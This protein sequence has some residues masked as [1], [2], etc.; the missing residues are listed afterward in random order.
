MPHRIFITVAEISGDRHAAQLVRS[1]RAMDP[2]LEIEGYG[3][4][5]LAA[6][7]VTLHRDMVAKAAMGIQGAFRAYEVYRLLR[8]TRRHFARHRPDLWIGV[9]SPSMNF[10]FARVARELGI[11]TLQ[12]VAPQLWAW[13]PWRMKKVR[14]RVDRLACILPFEERYFRDGGVN[15]DYIGHPLFD[16]L[17]RNRRRRERDPISP[18]DPGHWSASRLPPRRGQGEFPRSA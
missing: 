10:H 5:D 12:Y 7:G 13:A 4:P 8:W 18:I 9:D 3:G 17:P 11:P 6:E 14:K 2:S 16:E 15:A 1:L